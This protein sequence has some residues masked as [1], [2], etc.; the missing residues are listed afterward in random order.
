VERF[1]GDNTV[2]NGEDEGTEMNFR[3]A[4]DLGSGRIVVDERDSIGQAVVDELLSG[5]FP[6]EGFGSNSA[7]AG[8]RAVGDNVD[9][10]ERGDTSLVLETDEELLVPEGVG[11]I[12]EDG[13]RMTVHGRMVSLRS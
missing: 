2:L 10:N 6:L 9:G 7:E 1:R 13:D 8:V 12:E 5:W 4:D 11:E 3:D